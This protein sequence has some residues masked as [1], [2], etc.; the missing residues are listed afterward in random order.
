MRRFDPP[1]EFLRTASVTSLGH[2][3][4]SRMNHAANLRKEMSALLD[5]WLEESA[6][7]ML[8]RWLM[9]NQNLLHSAADE[10]PPEIAS[11]AANLLDTIVPSAS[12]VRPR[13]RLA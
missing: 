1:W 13:K 12:R 3:E 5:E 11:V 7:A 10:P 4:L 8:A 6:A 2:F 9:D